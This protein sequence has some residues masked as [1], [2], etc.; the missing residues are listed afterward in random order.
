MLFEFSTISI[1]F[2][3]KL[4]LK[5]YPTKAWLSFGHKP[6]SPGECSFFSLLQCCVCVPV[7]FLC[8]VSNLLPSTVSGDRVSFL[9][10]Q[11]QCL[12]LLE[13][14][15]SLQILLDLLSLLQTPFPCSF[16]FHLAPSPSCGF[17]HALLST[18]FFTWTF[19]LSEG[20]HSLKTVFF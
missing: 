15:V 10:T 18:V 1:T 13:F 12:D 20:S 6:S 17:L 8:A 14:D 9:L 11:G 7:L 2:A 3:I 4:L 5:L 16:S 19:F